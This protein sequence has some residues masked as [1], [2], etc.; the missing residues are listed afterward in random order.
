MTWAVY[1]LELSNGHYYT[2]I[3]NDLDKRLKA[4]RT[5]KGSKCVRAHLPF[6][7]VFTEKYSTKSVALKREAEIKKFSHYQKSVLIGGKTA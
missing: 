3:T 6:V 5:G 1:V 2:G 7:L 4:H